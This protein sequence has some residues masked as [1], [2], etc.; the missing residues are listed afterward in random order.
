MSN[1]LRCVA[2]GVALAVAAL[3]AGQASAQAYGYQDNGYQDNGYGNGYRHSRTVRCEST[4]SRRTFCRVNAYDG[5]RIVRQISHAACIEGRSWGSNDRGI[6][7]SS[8]CRADFAIRS[9]HHDDYRD[10]GDYDRNGYDDRR[11]DGQR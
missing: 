5:V 9:D 10:N 3:A 8:G 4:N 6:W 1:Q 11:G 7:V 2:V